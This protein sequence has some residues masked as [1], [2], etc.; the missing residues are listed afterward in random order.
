M[1]QTEMIHAREA[2]IVDLQCAFHDEMRKAKV[3][4][5]DLAHRMGVREIDIDHFFSERP[6]KVRLS[7]MAEMAHYL[8]MRIDIKLVEKTDEN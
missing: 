2:F 1:Q 6:T 5:H 4:R 3:S 7:F 8:E